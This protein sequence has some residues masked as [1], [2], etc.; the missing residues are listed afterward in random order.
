[1]SAGVAMIVDMTEYTYRAH[2]M[3]DD[4]YYLGLCLEFPNLSARGSTAHEAVAAVEK[5]VAEEVALLQAD[6]ETPPASLTDHHY[7]GKLLVRLP[8]VLHAKLAVEA[9]E[10]RMSL[11]Q[12]M[13]H[14]LSGRPS[15][16][17]DLF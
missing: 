4:R 1:M 3:P 12:W 14:K 11:N 13:I 15:M 6:D 7:S 10:Q 16:S 2:W 17:L 8:P 5:K 9:A